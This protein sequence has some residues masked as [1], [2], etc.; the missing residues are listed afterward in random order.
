MNYAAGHFLLLS[1]ARTSW[2]L[3]R[4]PFC[5]AGELEQRCTRSGPF[6]NMRPWRR[7][8]QLHKW[9]RSNYTYGAVH[10]PIQ[11]ETAT[12]PFLFTCHGLLLPFCTVLKRY[13]TSSESFDRQQSGS[14]DSVG[15][16]FF[17]SSHA[18]IAAQLAILTPVLD[19]VNAPSPDA[20][21]PFPAV[22]KSSSLRKSCATPPFG[23]GVRSAVS[24]RRDRQRC[25]RV[26]LDHQRS[27]VG[28]ASGPELLHRT[29]F[30]NTYN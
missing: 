26:G 5:K 9:C 22:P 16:Y 4:L 25:V 18:I 27:V 14:C 17:C 30:N 21:R 10:L 23:S 6:A 15:F 12:A 2:W 28:P 19:V 24:R 20:C 13:R 8:F 7:L 1:W 11:S 3:S 29:I